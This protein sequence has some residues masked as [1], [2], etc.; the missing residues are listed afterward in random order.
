MTALQASADSAENDHPPTPETVAG[1]PWHLLPRHEVLELLQ[2]RSSGL[3]PSEV[4]ARRAA[5]GANALPRKGRT[6]LLVVYL[7]QFKNPL[8]YLLLAATVVSVAVAE[9]ADA[10]FI[11]VVI[12]M[13]AVIGGVQEARAEASA[14]ALSHLVQ[15]VAEV[16]RGGRR[17]RVDAADL[18]P[19]DIVRLESGTSVPADLRILSLTELSVDESL[20]TGESTPVDKTPEAMARDSAPLGDRRNMLFAGATVLSGRVTGVVTATG[21]ETEIGRIAA[22]LEAGDMPPPPLVAGLKR[23][24]DVIGIATLVL[25]VLIGTVQF[26]QGLPLVTVF[27]VAVALAVA[28]IPEGLP[29]AI[30]IALAIATGRMAKRNVIVRALPAV[31][32][33]GSCTLIASD[34]TGTL[35]C[36]E[37]TVKRVQL[38]ADGAPGPVLRIGGEGFSLDGDVDVVDEA[39]APDEEESAGLAALAAGGALCNEASLSIEAG[40][41]EVVG[42]TVDVAFLVLGEKLGLCRKDLAAERPEMTL[43]PYEPQQRYGAVFTNEPGSGEAIVHVK[44]AAEVVLAMCAGVDADAALA[45]ADRM[46]A[47]GYRVLAVAGGQVPAEDATRGGR[48]ALRG[49]TFLGLVGLID[50]V[51]PEVPAAVAACRD[52]GIDVCMITGDHPATALAIARDLGI[53]AEAGEV[54]TGQRLAECGD[55]GDGFDA[56]VNR[57]RVFARI[58][59]VQKLAIVKALQRGGHVVAVSGDGVND[60]PALSAGDIGVAMGRGGTD[61]AREASDLVLADDNFASIVAGV[62]E[63]RIAYDNVRKL[64]FLL[65]TTGLGEIVLFLFAILAGLPPPLFAVQLLWLNLVTNG[66]QDVALAFERGEPGVL[67]R[68]PRPPG[69]RLFEKRM[70]TQVAVSGVVMGGI[71]FG[72][73]AFLMSR[74]VGDFEARNLLLLLMVLFENVHALNARSETRSILS[75]PFSANP[76]L[77]L[78]IL[79][80]QGL[81]IAAMHLPVLAD[82]LQVAPISWENWALVAL[83]AVSLVVVVEVLKL[84]RRLGERRARFHMSH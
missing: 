76:F 6:P 32:G 29:V 54:I 13:N 26:L 30:T 16:V 36:N 60:A 80:A 75:V 21:M 57:T 64:V 23:F 79:G 3:D 28:A 18:V 34:K 56:L 73:Y 42:D 7:R 5:F 78:A 9:W 4:A 84:I 24:G 55:D 62:E 70:I 27:L 22:A 67:K 1:H 82:V 43:I 20:L 19:G 66:I 74:G 63:G 52:A 69:E 53:A 31:E 35:T 2:T 51:R 45:A 15:N 37:L 44:G 77:I 41:T 48:S 71:A 17:V 8:I 39:R 50:P 61:A 12:Q 46:A 65:I 40:K 68:K 11:F 59:P 14:D 10:I 25:I 72:F 38:F 47:N 49:L 58:E 81:H 33:L 83:L